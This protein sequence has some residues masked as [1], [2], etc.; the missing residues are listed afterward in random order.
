MHSRFELNEFIR[1]GTME[2]S[3]DRA[4]TETLRL[5][6][7]FYKIKNAGQRRDIIDIVERLASDSVRLPQ[8][9]DQQ[10]KLK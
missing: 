6:L 3:D 5:M 7:A 9:N 2:E 1:A 4:N 10:T 8:D